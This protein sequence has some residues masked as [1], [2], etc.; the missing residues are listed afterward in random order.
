MTILTAVVDGGW[1]DRQA[2]AVVRHA[3]GDQ[4]V[5]EALAGGHD[6]VTC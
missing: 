1:V 4:V 5:A 2:H 6:L 3:R